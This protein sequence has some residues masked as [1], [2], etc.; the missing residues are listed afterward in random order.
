MENNTPT[1]SARYEAIIQE[2]LQAV[3]LLDNTIRY[4][5]MAHAYKGSAAEKQVRTAITNAN[6]KAA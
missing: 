5:E 2:L 4:S 6:G 3:R 1:S